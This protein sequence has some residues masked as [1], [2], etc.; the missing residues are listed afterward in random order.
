[1]RSIDEFR[2][3]LP[4]RAPPSHDHLHGLARQPVRMEALTNDESW[5]FFLSFI[6]GFIQRTTE[7]RDDTIT[8]LRDPKLVNDDLVR[9]L[10][11]EIAALDTRIAVLEEVI[12]LP[13]YLREQGEKARDELAKLQA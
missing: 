3:A 12:A 11:A 1:M 5:D 13:K 10:R 2:S 9:G 8:K 4:K 7:I 6:E